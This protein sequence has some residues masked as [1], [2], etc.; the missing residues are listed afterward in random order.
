[1]AKVAESF[2]VVNEDGVFLGAGENIAR[3]LK[4]AYSHESMAG[5]LEHGLTVIVV[6]TEIYKHK[7]EYHHFPHDVATFEYETGDWSYKT[8][9]FV[10]WPEEKHRFDEYIGDGLCEYLSRADLDD[11]ETNVVALYDMFSDEPNGLDGFGGGSFSLVG[12]KE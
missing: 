4:A 10:E 11:P 8:D 9:K 2:R 1:M 5:K 7:G 3:A 12:N 6:V